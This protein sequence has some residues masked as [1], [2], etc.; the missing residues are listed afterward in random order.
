MRIANQYALQILERHWGSDDRLN[1][2]RGVP[3]IQRAELT[4]LETLRFNF[5]EKEQTKPVK[6]NLS[7]IEIGY[8][9]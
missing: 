4:T 6:T 8:D 9:A 7:E 5:L 2:S 1:S 3:A